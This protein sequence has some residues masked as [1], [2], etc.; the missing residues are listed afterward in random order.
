MASWLSQSIC[1]SLAGDW[2]APALTEPLHWPMYMQF[3]NTNR[4]F[5]YYCLN[6]H[7]NYYHYLFVP[8]II[9]TWN[10]LYVSAGSLP[11]F[12]SPKYGILFV[13]FIT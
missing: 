9:P 8:H 12:L 13:L 6:V 3:P 10:G 5:L 4:P 2:N 11:L 1:N 7:T